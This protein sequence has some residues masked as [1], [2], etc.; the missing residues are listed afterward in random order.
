[1]PKI[2]RHGGVSSGVSYPVG[3][4]PFIPPPDVV[5]IIGDTSGRPRR[6][7]A[8]AAWV[9]Y[10]DSLGI[11]TGGLSKDQIIALVGG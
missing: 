9:A 10:A 6:S 4:L 2:T 7:A 5:K 3:L 11:A 1:M 8:K